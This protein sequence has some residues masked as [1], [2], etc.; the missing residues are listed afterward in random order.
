MKKKMTREE[1]INL[2]VHI[3]R[4]NGHKAR[5]FNYALCRTQA[6]CDEIKHA[7]E[8][9]NKPSADF[10]AYEKARLALCNELVEKDDKGQP[11]VRHVPVPGGGMRVEFAGL[12]TNPEF[13]PRMDVITEEYADAIEER[14][15]QT[16][17]VEERLKE[18]EEIELFMVKFEDVPETVTREEMKLLMPMILP[19]A[20][21]K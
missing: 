18:E 16:A 13:K 15:V 6:R 20:E 21:K 9:I 1:I 17:E 5:E 2:A 11:K 14:K 8:K 10:L 12:D 4:V 3:D 19:P 7:I